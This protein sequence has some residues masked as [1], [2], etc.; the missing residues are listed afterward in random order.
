MRQ[1]SSAIQTRHDVLYALK[2]EQ[3]LCRWVRKYSSKQLLKMNKRKGVSAVLS[4]RYS[5]FR[6]VTSP[7]AATGGHQTRS[8]VFKKKPNANRAHVI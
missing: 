6:S 2:Q 8:K 7:Y 3:L 4:P 1:K 5:V